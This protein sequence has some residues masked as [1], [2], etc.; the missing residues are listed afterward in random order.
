MASSLL[1]RR[2]TNRPGRALE[3]LDVIVSRAGLQNTP[4][5]IQ[6]E[7]LSIGA[8]LYEVGAS[9]SGLGSSAVSVSVFSSETRC[10]PSGAGQRPVRESEGERALPWSKFGLVFMRSVS[11]LAC[12]SSR[13]DIA[14]SY[15][16]A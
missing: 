10:K 1:L 13:T 16:L 15:T 7:R 14:L 2:G 6:R 4:M 9:S 5:R 8:V 11:H 12:L 3:W